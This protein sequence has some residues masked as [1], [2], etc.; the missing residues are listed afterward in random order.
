MEVDTNKNSECKFS[1]EN[2]T[3][4]QHRASLLEMF[5]PADRAYKCYLGNTDSVLYIEW[6]S[7]KN[8]LCLFEVAR[9]I[10]QRIES[11]N[12]DVSVALSKNSLYEYPVFVVLYKVSRSEI[13]NYEVEVK[14]IE[15]FKVMQVA[16]KKE[17][18][19]EKT[20]QEFA[21]FVWKVREFYKRKFYLLD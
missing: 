7:R 10:G 5:F 16:P 11:K 21:D 4:P 19:G 8:P 17:L 14:D 18:I 3:H 15:S 9:D 12:A 13:P 1:D 2:L 6:T 20:P